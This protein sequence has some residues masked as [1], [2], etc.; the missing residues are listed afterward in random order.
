MEI[1]DVQEHKSE[2]D[3]TIE[4]APNPEHRSNMKR[5][6]SKTDSMVPN[7]R[8][9]EKDV[10]YELYLDL[11]FSHALCRIL[12]LEIIAKVVQSHRH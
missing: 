1:E 9:Q 3:R 6:Q 8:I 4:G 2:F 12:L 5:F 7:N 10:L 11:Y